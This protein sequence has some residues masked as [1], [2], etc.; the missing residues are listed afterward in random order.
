MRKRILAI[1]VAAFLILASFAGCG[2][3]KEAA[4]PSGQSKGYTDEV[5]GVS[6]DTT[7]AADGAMQYSS[8]EAPQ[9]VKGD[10]GEADS[11]A[12]GGSAIDTVNSAILSERKII[13][14]ANI[15]LEV[16][17][18]DEALN[19]VYTI[20]NGIGIVQNSNVVTDKIYVDGEYKPLKNG[21]IVLRVYKEKFD[22]V[23]NNLKGIGEV[24]NEN[25]NGEDVTDRYIDTE[26]R[27]RL[28]KMEQEKL[29]AYLAK[30]D[31][32][33][34]IFK[35]E[36]RL[37]EIRYEIESLTGSLNKMSSLVELSTITI[38]MR[39]KNPYE[40]KKPVKQTYWNRVLENLKS[41]FEGVIYFLGDFFIFIVAAIPVLLM[42]GLF[43]LLIWVIVR[44]IKKRVRHSS[45]PAINKQ[46]PPAIIDN[47]QEKKEE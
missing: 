24:T 28:L 35:T 17:N 32:L 15:S 11:I 30:L 16:D 33:D 5:N 27:L 3:K 39:E 34:K 14:S 23:L 18:F 21:T 46:Q 41:S 36:S 4:M 20:I 9:E 45:G 22:S 25:I 47:T 13:R 31:D 19:S 44:R 43:G 10:S 1:L 42:L 40:D 8:A 29:E 12:G 26:S 38:S 7:A 37:T 6:F 2:S